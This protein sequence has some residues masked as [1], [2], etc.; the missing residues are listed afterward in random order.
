M[1]YKNLCLCH[2]MADVNTS[3]YLTVTGNAWGIFMVN[4]YFN[5]PQKRI[6]MRK[7]FLFSAQIL[8][9]FLISVILDRQQSTATKIYSFRI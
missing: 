7:Q 3:Y 4:P 5:M 9:F 2:E 1:L 8:V 6:S